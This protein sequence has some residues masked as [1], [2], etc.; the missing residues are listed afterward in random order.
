MTQYILINVTIKFITKNTLP[1]QVIINAIELRALLCLT[2]DLRMVC[3][4]DSIIYCP[5]KKKQGI[6]FITAR[7]A[8]NTVIYLH[9]N[10]IDSGK[11]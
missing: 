6:I 11:L 7:P 4:S 10:S 2:N 1:V 3:T 8:D 9:S 5:S